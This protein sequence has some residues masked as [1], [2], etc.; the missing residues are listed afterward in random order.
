MKL[1]VIAEGV[2]TIEQLR[3]LKEQ[4]CDIAQGYLFSRP[5]PES[6]VKELLVSKTINI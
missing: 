4:S 5:I 6:E 3:F 1:D 2:E